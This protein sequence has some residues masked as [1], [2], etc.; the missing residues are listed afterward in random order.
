MVVLLGLKAKE[1]EYLVKC[2]KFQFQLYVIYNYVKHI[3]Y[4]QYAIYNVYLHIDYMIY[5]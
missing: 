2:D 5:N 1:N 4:I 3:Y